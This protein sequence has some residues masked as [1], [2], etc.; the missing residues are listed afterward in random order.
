MV[1]KNKQDE[2]IVVEGAR[3]LSEVL[4][5]LTARVAVGVTGEDLNMQAEELIA[6]AGGEPAFKGYGSPPFPAVLCVSRNECVVHGVPD[7][8]PFAAG[9]IIGLDIGMRYQGFY[10]DM[11]RTVMLQPNN[12]REQELARTAREA[13]DLACSL[14]RPGITTGDLGYHIQRFV[15]SR[16]FGVVRDLAGHGL[17]TSLHE[18]PEIPNFGKP[19]TGTMLASGMLLAIEPMITLG[20]Y[21]LRTASDH[22]SMCTVDGSK[23]AHEEDMVLV[24]DNGS[25]V[26]TR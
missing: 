3:R 16:G 9:D 18:A 26:L 1:I 5:R 14:V 17:G 4:S 24:T 15:E 25:R 12:A 7:N 2:D 8:R 11:A 21:R 13:L 6:L 19:G 10:M 22:W 23:T 20:S